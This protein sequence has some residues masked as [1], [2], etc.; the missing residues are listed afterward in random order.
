MRLQHG[1]E[2]PAPGRGGARKRKRGTD[3]QAAPSRGPTP[4]PIPTSN[5]AFNTFKVEPS[6]YPEPLNGSHVRE[7]PDAHANGHRSVSPLSPRLRRRRH[8]SPDQDEGYNSAASDALP[9]HLLPH[10]VPATNLVLGRSPSMVMYLLMKAKHRY[11]VEQHESLL[12]ELR[13]AR[14]ELRR[15]NE[16]KEIALDELLRGCFG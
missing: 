5:G 8:A 16:E 6:P 15:E 13:V 1:I 12:E 4:P 14:S 7:R 10:Y 2:P 11:A 3:D 9:A